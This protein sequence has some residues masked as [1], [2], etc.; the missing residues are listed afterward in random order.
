MALFKPGESGN[1]N[2]RPKKTEQ[3]KEFERKCQESLPEVYQFLS[4]VFKSGKIEDRKWAAE[5]LLDRSCGRPIQAQTIDADINDTRSMV[6]DFGELANK[7][8]AVRE[9]LT[10]TKTNLSGN[11]GSNGMDQGK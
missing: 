8:R 9:A 7:A 2:G 6:G 10:G 4:N 11:S 1:P 5:I 3:Q